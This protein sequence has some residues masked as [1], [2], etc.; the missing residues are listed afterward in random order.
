MEASRNAIPWDDVGPGW[1]VATWGP[2]RP[3][4]LGAAV[5]AGQ[6][7]S[8]NEAVTLYLVDPEGG[9]YRIATLPPSPYGSAV[10]ESWSGDGKRVLLVTPTGTPNVTVRVVALASGRS[11]TF[12]IDNSIG[13]VFGNPDGHDLLA[14][15]TTNGAV[16][17]ERTNLDGKV[18]LKYPQTS[19]GVGRFD[20]YFASSPN[21]RIIAMGEQ[22]GR[23]ALVSKGGGRIRD[24]VVP[25]T[26]ECVPSRWWSGTEVL[27]SCQPAG[28]KPALLWLVPTSGA[29]PSRFTVAGSS[30]ADQGDEAAWRV[31]RSVYVQ[32]E[33]GC[34]YEDVAKRNAHHTT[35]PVYVPLE[36]SHDSV[37]VLG[38]TGHQM[39]VQATLACGPGRALLWLDPAQGVVKVVLGSGMNGGSVTSA[40]LFGVDNR[41]S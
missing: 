22:D 11:H 10:L 19:S 24:V 29:K 36:N 23:V 3:E 15:A 9:R 37:A 1:S 8:S 30:G 34:G 32:N 25:G 13:A 16:T 26:T 6:P 5:P 12:A 40:L 18:D 4:P 31:G 39:L 17:L 28:N 27:V 41:A 38:A 7:T 21:G 20:G 35:S 14:V 33:G 2:A